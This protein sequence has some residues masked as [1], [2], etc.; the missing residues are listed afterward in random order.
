MRYIVYMF[1]GLVGIMVLCS[2]LID[3]VEHSWKTISILVQASGER[4]GEWSAI[5]RTRTEADVD[6]LGEGSGEE[7]ELVRWRPGGQ[8]VLIQIIDER[9]VGLADV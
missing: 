2:S 1:G 9:A 8:C 5:D 7:V 6:C 3:R 4:G